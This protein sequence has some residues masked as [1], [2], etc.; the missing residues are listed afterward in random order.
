MSYLSIISHISL[1]NEVM[2]HPQWHGIEGAVCLTSNGLAVG[3]KSRP[4]DQ[5]EFPDPKMEV[6]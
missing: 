3:E 2:V 4:F 5:W 6:R 1:P